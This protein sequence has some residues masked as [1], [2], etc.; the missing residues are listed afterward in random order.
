MKYI[1]SFLAFLI[2]FNFLA[3]NCNALEPGDQAPPLKVATWLKNGP[4]SLEA[5][6]GHTIYV[7]EFWTTWF[8]PCIKALP[9]LS[10]IQKTFK[11]RGV[12]VVGI[13]NEPRDKVEEF[14]KFNEKMINYSIGLD[15]KGATSKLYTEGINVIPVVYIVGKDGKIKWRG[16]IYDLERVLNSILKGQFNLKTQ[17][18]V[19]QLQVEMQTALQTNKRE[20][21]IQL[22]EKILAI[23][24]KNEVALQ[25]I[26][27]NYERNQDFEGALT[28]LD[29]LIFQVPNHA[30]LYFIKLN[31][32]YRN[33]SNA[34]KLQIFAERMQSEFINNPDVLNSLAWT[35]LNQQLFGLTPLNV[36]LSAAKTSIKKLDSNAPP[37]KRSIFL[38]T[39]AKAY[40]SVGN[41]KKAI[42][43]QQQAVKYAKNTPQAQIANLILLYYQKAQTLGKYM[44]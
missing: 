3:L 14:L 6:K 26:L 19:S 28:L 17:N 38:A 18:K 2:L 15:D 41:I 27:F 16:D 37:V 13:I 7:L 44:N 12:V 4:V 10:H 34:L 9:Y 39:L 5:G 11:N 42:K 43:I 1:K 29:K 31:M 8:A 40:Y 23:D 21:A 32:L 20:K 30:P 36:A 35:L 22:A 25:L 24:P 33:P